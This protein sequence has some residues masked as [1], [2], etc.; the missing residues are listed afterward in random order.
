[1]RLLMVL[2]FCTWG[3]SRTGIERE[4]ERE[5]KRKRNFPVSH[6]SH[7][8]LSSSVFLPPPPRPLKV[9]GERQLVAPGPAALQARHHAVLLVLPDPLL[10]KVGLALQ[11]QHLHPVERVGGLVVLVR[12]QRDEEAVGDELDVLGHQVAVHADQA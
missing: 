12:A 5:G 7:P 11:R 8:S 1:M 3:G 4:R 2:C 9:L 10:E 6:V